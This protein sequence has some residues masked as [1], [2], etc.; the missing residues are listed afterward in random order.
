MEAQ[1]QLCVADNAD[2]TIVALGTN[3]YNYSDV[4]SVYQDCL[5]S[6]W[7]EL[8]KPI[9]CMGVLP[10]S[11]TTQRNTVNGLIQAAVAHSRNSHGINAIYWGTD[12]WIDVPT[13]TSDGLHLTSSGQAKVAAQVLQRI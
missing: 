10:K 4:Q 5:E 13:D 12:D 11:D 8:S 1:M 2:F 6:L 7:G 9:Y 3:D